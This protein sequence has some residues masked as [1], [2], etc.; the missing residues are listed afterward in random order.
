VKT[1]A[2]GSGRRAPTTPRAGSTSSARQ[3]FP[4][5]TIP[6]AAGDN[7]TPTP[8]SRSIS[9]RAR[10]PGISI[11]VE[12]SGTTTRSACTALR[13]HGQ[14]ARSARSS[15]MFRAQR[16]LLH[17]RPGHWE[18][19]Q[20][21]QYVTDLNW[22]KASIQD[23]QALRIDPSSAS[24][25]QPRGARAARR[26]QEEGCHLARRRRHQPTAFHPVRHRLRVGIRSCFTQNGG[27]VVFS[28]DGDVDVKATR[29]ATHEHLYYGRSRLSTRSSNGSS[30]GGD[31]YRDPLGGDRHRGRRGVHGPQDGWVVATTTR[32]SR[33]CG[34]STSAT[35]L[36]G[37]PS[38]TRS[39]EAVSRGQSAGATHPG[40]VRQL[41]NS[42]YCSVFH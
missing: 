29:S 23:R 37:A 3:P 30:E 41:E 12:D 14:R 18:I 34:A 38:P 1:A 19:P 5:S 9:I 20:G 32:R 28:Q 42:S 7:S 35:P 4:R 39:F 15:A 8:R 27:P 21:R 16:L 6:G 36:K 17:A 2:G 31:R 24:D 13:R 22:T 40:E 10:S 33:S 11:H 25:L 26:R